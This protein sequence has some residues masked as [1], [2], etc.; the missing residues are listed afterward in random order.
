MIDI[1]RII[2]LTALVILATPIF[3]GGYLQAAR[4][5]GTIVDPALAKALSGTATIQLV[6]TYDHKPTSSDASFLQNLG[7]KYVVLDQLPMALV[8]GTPSQAQ[9][10]IQQTSIRSVW[11]NNALSYYRQV[12]TVN[13]DYGTVPVST[14]WWIDTMNVRSAWTQGARGT[15]VG[16]AIVDSGVDATNPSLGYNFPNGQSYASKR[17]I[18]NVK[19]VALSEI[20]FEPP[21]GPDQLYIENQ[22]NTDTTGGHGT[23]TSSSAAG[24]GVASDGVYLGVAPEANVVGLSAGDAI[25]VF[26]AV[27]SFN[28][29][30]AHRA[31]YNIRVNSNSW[32]PGS[33]SSSCFDPSDPVNVATKQMHDAGIARHF[34]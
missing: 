5:T 10:V 21:I 7:V 8:I 11:N 15:G 13:H 17:V 27:A 19:V 29:I 24:T 1:R 18:Q 2:L 20:V 30:L 25:A 3:T 34:H 28:Y 4:A 23:G 22:P 14:S 12:N 32:G 6:V 33:D 16:V 26:Y 9:S 31:Q